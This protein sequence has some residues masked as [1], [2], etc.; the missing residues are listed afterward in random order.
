M[1]RRSTLSIIREMAIK[2][3]MRYPYTP[4]RMATIKR[5]IIADVGKD[6][7]TLQLS[8]NVDG[9]VKWN[10]NLGKQFGIFWLFYDPEIS[11][12]VIYQ[13]A[14]KTSDTKTC[15]H[16]FIAALLISSQLETTKRSINWWMDFKNAKNIYCLIPY[17][18]LFHIHGGIDSKSPHVYQNPPVLKSHS[19]PFVFTGFVSAD[20]TNR[21]WKFR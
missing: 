13:R 11:F 5:P 9:K 12:L 18:V 10:R 19:P 17:T 7:G 8:Y 2:I 4:A 1:K 20:S 21:R 15:A 3:T 6:W 14:V 16:T